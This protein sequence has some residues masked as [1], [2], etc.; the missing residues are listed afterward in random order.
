MGVNALQHR[1]SVG[2]FNCC[3]VNKVSRINVRSMSVLSQLDCPSISYMLSLIFYIYIM[4]YIISMTLELGILNKTGNKYVTNRMPFSS[5]LPI[6][7]NYLYYA[8]LQIVLIGILNSCDDN[9]SSSIGRHSSFLKRSFCSLL[10]WICYLIIL[11]IFIFSINL[12]LLVIC[13]TSIINPG[14]HS[15]RS[16]SVF[17]N[18]VQGL[19]NTR[20][21]ASK[22]P[23]LNMTKIHELHGFLYT[24][25]PDLVILNETW[26]K[27]SISDS[28]IFPDGYKIF[29]LDRSERTH[30]YDPSQPKKFRKNGGGVLIAHRI[31]L[32]ISSSKVSVVKA[33]AELLSIILKLP[34]GTKLCISTFYRVGTLEE[35]NFLEV[36]RYFRTLASKK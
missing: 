35:A 32:D 30:P 17:Y 21:L 7:G 28:E 22:N 4:L 13:N 25:K 31:D 10:R 24:K 8:A 3:Q 34:T 18:N 33:Q 16:L 19:V 27:G 12:I 5:S 11:S 26:L 29:R 23:P 15:G 14:P 6:L 36:E 9:V 2:L 1:I 20:D